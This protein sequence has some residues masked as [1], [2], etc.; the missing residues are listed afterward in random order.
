VI[1]GDPAF[2][3]TQ[4]RPGHDIADRVVIALDGPD[5]FELAFEEIGITTE[6]LGPLSSQEQLM[7][8]LIARVRRA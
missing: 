8:D 5:V 3:Y 1:G 2:T 7:G 6:S 4:T